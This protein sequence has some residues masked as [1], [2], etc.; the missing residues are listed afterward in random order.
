MIRLEVSLRPVDEVQQLRDPIIATLEHRILE[1]IQIADLQMTLVNIA[2]LTNHFNLTTLDTILGIRDMHSMEST[3]MPILTG[4][5][6]L[7]ISRF[8]TYQLNNFYH[9]KIPNLSKKNVPIGTKKIIVHIDTKINSYLREYA[10]KKPEVIRIQV[11]EMIR[12]IREDSDEKQQI[13]ANLIGVSQSY[14]SKQERGEKP[15]RINQ[16]KTICLHYR[17]SSDYILGHPKR[18]KWPR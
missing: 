7:I 9:N 4:L 6:I 12:G 17:V 16:I 8:N 15:F 2:G 13:I 11:H 14:Y 3:E 10:K 18:L 5:T 1:F